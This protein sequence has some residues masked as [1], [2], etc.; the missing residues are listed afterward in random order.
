[1]TILNAKEWLSRGFKIDNQIASKLEQIERWRDLAEKTTIS[2]GG[3]SYSGG[4][5]GNSRIEEYCVKIADAEREVQKELNRLVDI[6]CEI[7][8]LIGKIRTTT[9]RIL[10]EQRYLC[11]KEWSNIAEF[12]NYT[13]QYIKQDLHKIALREVEKLLNENK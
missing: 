1:M 6:E 10:L 13:E 5:D 2:F 3:M 9:Q 4:G 12:M 7:T 11:N 8:S